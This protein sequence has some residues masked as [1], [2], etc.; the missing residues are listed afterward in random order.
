M[1]CF[2]QFS[3]S[4]FYRFFQQRLKKDQG[5]NGRTA[6]LLTVHMT[7]TENNER[8]S[9]SRCC[10]LSSYEST[11][12]AK[13]GF[14]VAD[15]CM[16]SLGFQSGMYTRHLISMGIVASKMKDG[17]GSVNRI[18]SYFFGSKTKSERALMES[19]ANAESSRESTP[20][21]F[22]AQ[23]ADES[24]SPDKDKAKA[25]VEVEEV[26]DLQ[27]ISISSSVKKTESPSEN[28]LPKW[29]TVQDDKVPG[30]SIKLIVENDIEIVEPQQKNDFDGTG[31]R[32]T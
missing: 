8:K 20:E 13:D 12:L 27:V 31:S 21:L 28:Q 32:G 29:K 17:K 25:E 2:R 6:T 30:P 22:D 3:H 18:E 26:E 7:F 23:N 15:K 19:D 11:D 1:N 14:L 9:I 4:A 16:T 24:R 10:P 5:D